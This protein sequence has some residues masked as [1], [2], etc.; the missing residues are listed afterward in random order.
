MLAT[1]DTG[2][3]S[4]QMQKSV[5]VPLARFGFLFLALF[6]TEVSAE[7]NAAAAERKQKEIERALEQHEGLVSSGT[8]STQIRDVY[9]LSTQSLPAD[10]DDDGMP[11][12]WEWAN[13][14]DPNNRDDAWLDPD[15][16]L[17][18]NLFE[19]QLDS[20]PNDPATPPVVTVAPSGADYTDVTTAIDS[21]A[22]GTVIR[23]AEGFY[24][25]NYQ[26]FNSKIVM[27][28]GGWKSDFTERELGL[29]ST[30]FDGGMIEEKEVLYFSVDS[31]KPVIII[32]GIHFINGTGD[33][34]AINLLASGSAFMRTS[35]VNCSITNS[36]NTTS[37]G[38]VL[39]IF[40]WDTSISDRTIANTLIANND[41]GAL[42]TTSTEDSSAHWRII[43]TTLAYNR[44]EG[45][46]N[47]YGIRG[48]TLENGIIKSHIYNN[49][50]WGNESQDLSIEG[51]TTFD[52]EYSDIGNIDL[53]VAGI[54]NAWEGN[55]DADPL[56]LDVATGDFHLSAASPAIDS[57]ISLGAP[58]IDIE[59]RVRP[60]GNGYDMGAFEYEPGG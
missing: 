51:N 14:L 17:V 25:V 12:D 28:Q 13:G 23:I 6:L 37:F 8:P 34:G 60:K 32:D 20:N 39:S 18:I 3:L 30:T 53:G 7:T 1:P 40:N 21:V 10:T 50:V 15:V 26:T 52:V 36:R 59:S 58:P 31:G 9:Q 33:F 19:Y 27:I 47:G 38:G 43:N 45:G 2:L 42:Y 11:D 48:F 56:F 41:A 4:R 46:D 16:D 55:I 35:V 5:V 29:Y 22:P 54:Y 57:G 44:N 49:I 24:S